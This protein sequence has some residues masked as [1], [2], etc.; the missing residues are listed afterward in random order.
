M[1]ASVPVVGDVYTLAHPIPKIVGGKAADPI[2]HIKLLRRPNLGVMKAVT[3]QGKFESLGTALG[4]ITD[5]PKAF[6]DSV[7]AEDAIG[8]SEWLFP[9]FNGAGEK[10]SPEAQPESP[11]NASPTS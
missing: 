2:A 3:G 9:L 4:M 11:D 1:S 6:V 8:L 10:T 5:L 7:D